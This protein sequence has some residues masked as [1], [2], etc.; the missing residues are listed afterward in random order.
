MERAEGVEVIGLILQAAADNINGHRPAIRDLDP[1]AV[2]VLI[3]IARGVRLNAS[4]VYP[5]VHRV[6]QP[7]LLL[8]RL[9]LLLSKQLVVPYVA[10]HGV[11]IGVATTQKLMVD[12]A[13]I[14]EQL[15]QQTSVHV[16]GGDIELQECQPALHQ[17][18]IR[19]L[20]FFV[21]GLVPF[22]DIQAQAADPAAGA[23]FHRIP[24]Y[25]PNDRS[26]LPVHRSR[27]G[28]VGFADRCGGNRQTCRTDLWR[29]SAVTAERNRINAGTRTRRRIPM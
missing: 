3:V 20:R 15:G 10:W 28:R 8:A 1:L 2:G 11:D 5:H 6:P 23:W 9:S 19:L 18:A 12:E 27:H 25:H 14:N 17:L 29:T 7:D 24:V 16:L 13:T 22:R 26:P 21:E 4:D